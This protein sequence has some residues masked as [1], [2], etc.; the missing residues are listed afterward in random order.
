MNYRGFMA[1]KKWKKRGKSETV[2]IA[3]ALLSALR[4]AGLKDQA[5]KLEIAS[6]YVEAVGHV[7]AK[8][9]EPLSF[10]RGVLVIK[11]SSPAWQNE[12]TFL[13]GDI[14]TQ[15]NNSLGSEVV[16]EIKVVAGN[17]GAYVPPPEP[18]D[19]RGAWVD[20]APDPTDT[21]EVEA[22]SADIEDPYIRQRFE[23]VMKLAR[24]AD[25]HGRGAREDD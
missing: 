5:M 25:R 20:E 16:K 11:S 7:I 15:I 12:L 9:S 13:K 6:S 8:R 24:R 19:P 17:R 4:K 10:S 14:I 21:E 22:V 1:R 18:E 3:D 2:G 23:A